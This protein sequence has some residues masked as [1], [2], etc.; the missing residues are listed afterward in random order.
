MGVKIDKECPESIVAVLT[1]EIDH[2]SAAFMRE[3]IDKNITISAAKTIVLDFSGVTFMDS[4]AVGL[5]MGRYRTAKS[6]GSSVRLRG[7][8]GRNK[9]IMK[10]AGLDKIITIEGENN[11][12]A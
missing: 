2:H 7:L 11:E 4:S 9:L 8:S 12:K 6:C 10:M 1:G 3:Y 5:V